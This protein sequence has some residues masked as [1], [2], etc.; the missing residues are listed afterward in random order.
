MKPVGRTSSSRCQHASSTAKNGMNHDTGT[1]EALPFVLFLYYGSDGV[2]ES[3]R[4]EAQLPQELR[5][6]GPLTK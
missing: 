2:G 5:R 4:L 3:R 6:G 1:I